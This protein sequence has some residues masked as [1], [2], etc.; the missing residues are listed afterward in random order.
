M[1]QRLKELIC[2]IFRHRWKVNPDSAYKAETKRLQM[3]LDCARCG[4][5]ACFVYSV[6]E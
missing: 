6:E 5:R 3:R 2:R 4:G 1:T